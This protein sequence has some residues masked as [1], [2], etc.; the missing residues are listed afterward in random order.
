MNNSQPFH[1]VASVL[2]MASL[3]FVTGSLHAHTNLYVSA[4]GSAQF[5]TVQAA[6]MAVPAGSSSNRV[7][8][9]IKPGTYREVIYV[10]R[11]KRFFH[12][13]GESA[14]KTILTF[15]LNANIRGA[16][17]KPIGTFRTPTV[18]ID[19]EDFTAE[20]VTF[21]NSAGPVGQALAI[22][23]DGDRAAFRNCRFLG[24]QDTILLNRG[25]QYFENCYIEGHVD[26]IFGGATAYF[27]KCH[28]HCLR[29][30]YITAAS[31]P[32][33]QK[34]GFVFANGR[35]TGTNDVKTYLGRPW[36]NFAS[37][38]FLNTSMSEVVRP[39]GWHNWNKKDAEQT[40]RYAEHGNTGPGAV[41][42]KRVPWIRQLSDA[43]AKAI[44][45]HSVLGGADGWN[46]LKQVGLDSQ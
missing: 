24:W 17:G 15:D 3:L 5:T 43:E 37:T 44:T 28:I 34:F 25:R 14:E 40:T 41:V 18:L 4:D 9:H 19:A 36:R 39:E 32:D 46:P 35:I 45:P 22:R 10:Q 30:G 38:V 26:F 16:D 12:F 21:E 27:E 31:T 20:N 6:V 8:I 7:F 2:A 33:T 11:E 29:N 13:I 1:G 23:V 42:E